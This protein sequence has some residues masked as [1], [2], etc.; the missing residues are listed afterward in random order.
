MLSLSF[1]AAREHTRDLRDAAKRDRV[2]AGDTPVTRL[3]L[4]YA[5]AADADRLQALAELDSA[6]PLS[7]PSLV[8]EIDGRLRAALPLNGG[9][10]IADPFHRGAELIELLRMRAAQLC[11]GGGTWRAQ[12]A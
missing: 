8:A 4:R 7:G 11:G 1:L 2:E 10:P 5:S 6:A 3:T 12:R 9:E